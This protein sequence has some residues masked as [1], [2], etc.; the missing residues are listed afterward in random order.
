MKLLALISLSFAP[1]SLGFLASTPHRAVPMCLFGEMVD[2][3][4]ED[5]SE[6]MDKSVDSVKMN[7]QTVRTG[8]ANAQMLDRV[9]VDYYGAETPLNQMATISV[10]SAQQLSIDPYDKS[11][12][13]A[14]ETTIMESDLGLTPNNDG[15]IIRI[16]IPR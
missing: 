1:F 13:A 10:P 3:V 11:T 9:K 14:I 4:S 8:R 5:T 16:N 15:N 2:M 12:L 7:L 6:R